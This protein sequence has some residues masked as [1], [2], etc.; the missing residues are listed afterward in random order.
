MQSRRPG[1]DGW[2]ERE[3]ER[4]RES[5]YSVLSA[6]PNDNDIRDIQTLNKMEGKQTIMQY[7]ERV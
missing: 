4:E 7:V 1:R 3:R 5:E 2:R 6:R